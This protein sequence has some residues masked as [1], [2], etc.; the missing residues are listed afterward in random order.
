MG[1]IFLHPAPKPIEPLIKVTSD[2]DS[3]PDT[4]EEHDQDYGQERRDDD[5]EL[6]HFGR[7]AVQRRQ[8]MSVTL[9][10]R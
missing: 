7:P 1:R 9:T 10:F 6:G 3:S 2:R 8:L 4:R 5:H